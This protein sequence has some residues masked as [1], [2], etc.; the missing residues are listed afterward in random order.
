MKNVTDVFKNA[1]LKS[2]PPHVVKTITL[3]E[4]Q[5]DG[6]LLNEYDISTYLKGGL[7]LIDKDVETQLNKFVAGE[8]TLKFH[9]PDKYLNDIL[10]QSNRKFGLKV[11]INFYGL[12]VEIQNYGD[13][14]DVGVIRGT[15]RFENY[16]IAIDYSADT[17]KRG[18]RAFTKSGSTFTQVSFLN[19]SSYRGWR[20]KTDGEYIL[21]CHGIHGLRAYTFEDDIFTQ[22]GYDS[23]AGAVYDI[24]YDSNSNIYFV[25]DGDRGL[26]AC[27]FNG[28][29]F[30]ELGRI[31]PGADG[32]GVWVDSDGYIFYAD[33]ANGL[34]VYTFDGVSTFTEV[35]H[36]TIAGEA[37]Q[38]VWGDNNGNIFVADYTAGGTH[39]L[40]AYTWDSGTETLTQKDN[41]YNTGNACDVYGY[42][43]Y[44]GVAFSGW[45]TAIFTFD[46]TDL[47]LVDQLFESGESSCESVFMEAE[48]I[49]SGYDSGLFAYLYEQQD[50]PLFDG[51]VDIQRITR[52]G[53]NTLSL[54]AQTWEKELE[55][56]NAELVHDETGTYFRN[57]TGVEFI[58]LAGGT[59][60]AK[61]LN[62]TYKTILEGTDTVEEF[63]LSYE[64]GEEFL[65]REAGTYSIV[66]SSGQIVT[67]KIDD[68]DNLP[69]DDAE[70][71]LVVSST[72]SGGTVGFWHESK[73]LSQL[74][75][76]LLDRT[77]FAIP[78][79]NRE[80]NIDISPLLSTA[81]QFDY[82]Q[83]ATIAGDDIHSCI[84]DNPTDSDNILISLGVNVCKLSYDS[85]DREFTV[86][87]LLDI[88]ATFGGATRVDK[89]LRLP[90]GDA[91]VVCV[92]GT[93]EAG[94]AGWSDLEGIMQI[95][96]DGTIV[97][98]WNET[99]LRNI[100]GNLATK[101]AGSSV[102]LINYPKPTGGAETRNGFYW[103]QY[104]YHQV[105]GVW[106]RS[107][108]ISY[109][110]ID[111]NPA[112]IT[113]T[114][115]IAS[116]PDSTDFWVAPNVPYCRYWSGGAPSG[117]Y[118]M[119]LYANNL[120][121]G[122]KS[123]GSV[124][125][126][127]TY[128]TEETINSIRAIRADTTQRKFYFITSKMA[129]EKQYVFK[130]TLVGTG[131]SDINTDPVD[132][133]L[134]HPAYLINL[135]KPTAFEM[136][137]SGNA[138][139]LVELKWGSG[140]DNPTIENIGVG[141]NGYMY[142]PH[143][144]CYLSSEEFYI[145]LAE[146]GSLSI[147]KIFLCVNLVDAIIPIADFTGM[148]VRE[149]LNELAS[150]F[151]CVWKR[152]ERDTVRFVSR[153]TYCDTVEVD[154]NLYKSNWK[155]SK[156]KPYIGVEIKNPL[157]EQY[158]YRY[159]DNFNAEEGEVFRLSNRF[160]MPINGPLLAKINGDWFMA[161]RDEIEID[162]FFL[163]EL[164]EFDLIQWKK[165]LVDGTPDEQVDCV[166]MGISYDDR[167]KLTRI[168]MVGVDSYP[169]KKVRFRP[170]YF[171]SAGS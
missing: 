4:H 51:L 14:S 22:V 116:E 145:G 58:S 102:E 17:S 62:Y 19:L 72:Q 103:L 5:L 83:E 150:G 112:T 81:W 88:T 44:I 144:V 138:H 60:G 56:H 98:T 53:R 78:D 42:G 130:S 50:L 153:G 127:L 157:Y 45:G 75:E 160:A 105:L 39:G 111:T 76:L 129:S 87:N 99:F 136:D 84:E 16:I 43:N 65:F 79:A 151:N 82:I 7:P 96:D 25:A 20:V 70:D 143:P 122:L 89:I 9:D 108:Y 156:T 55:H 168:R 92:S 128:C 74:V 119:Y 109:V 126:S 40:I 148:N 125:E 31:D 134:D 30:T 32:L 91:L 86:T 33:D 41:Y 2:I 36:V 107:F 140:S 35:E 3:S 24:H 117:H 137:G 167:T 37:F 124:D 15:C 149:A 28:S 13:Y 133:T 64:D 152:M 120:G 68:I 100:S 67:L 47:T 165:Y 121:G 54:S 101:I 114:E 11:D 158:S 63:G 141:F 135:P 85:V 69:K 104:Y 113:D 169:F 171:A 59:V 132:F 154:N 73:R 163:V 77:S 8:M 147:A 94:Y 155:E 93:K 162:G 27:T 161:I 29:T 97:D 6:T 118:Y 26:Y 61:K 164:E 23:T 66:G 18:L 10:E 131:H 142:S 110:D 48:E 38:K 12:D 146:M 52:F 170:N 166:L 95:Q 115:L 80:I 159:P 139:N 46:G 49:F 90:N 106:T 123:S 34:Y 1:R 71:V 21:G 57:I